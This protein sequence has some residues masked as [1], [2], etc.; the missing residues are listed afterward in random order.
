MLPDM[1][2]WLLAT[3]LTVIAAV[4]GATLLEPHLSSWG[5]PSLV[6]RL[7][8][9]VLGALVMV[10]FVLSG[11]W[12]WGSG[13]KRKESGRFVLAPRIATFTS[14]LA[15]GVP[16][17]LTDRPT[18]EVA[19]AATR[20]AFSLAGT[21]PVVVEPPTSPSVVLPPPVPPAP[22]EPR[23]VFARRWPSAP[24]VP[25][26]PERPL[27]PPVPEQR[28]M[29][30][31]EPPPLVLL[32][33]PDEPGTVLVYEW[34]D[35]KGETHW[36]NELS[37]LPEG[38]HVLRVVKMK[39]DTHSPAP[40]PTMPTATTRPSEY[41]T[42]GD[43]F[44]PSMPE[45]YWRNKFSVAIKRQQQVEGRVKAKRREIDEASILVNRR[46]MEQQLRDL[47][48]EL[49]AAQGEVQDL[50]REASYRAVPREW[51]H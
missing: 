45:M 27:E 39:L 10:P 20:T 33:P 16:L 9:V 5:L 12:L 32:P 2:R 18:V 26:V 6:A 4:S 43:S 30:V 1:F 3:V 42:G 25:V 46:V 44:M 29:K 14:A 17:L 19:K 35:A 36:A 41:G 22:P 13:L 11:D 51:R 38:S 31:E 37:E 40:Q 24:E 7:P 23:Q 15:L 28:P 47:E 49:K 21:P 8:W 34:R 50:E 48:E